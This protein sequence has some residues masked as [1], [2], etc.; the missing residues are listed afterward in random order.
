MLTTIAYVKST[1]LERYVPYPTCECD[2][3]MTAL[4]KMQWKGRYYENIN[5]YG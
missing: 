4:R 5:K 3:D 2:A 1:M